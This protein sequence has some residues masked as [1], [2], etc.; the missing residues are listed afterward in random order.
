MCEYKLG[1]AVPFIKFGSYKAL[2]LVSAVVAWTLVVFVVALVAVVVV[3]IHWGMLC[4]V[5]GDRTGSYVL[6]Q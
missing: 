2:L 6:L 5:C 3:I 4:E 1:T